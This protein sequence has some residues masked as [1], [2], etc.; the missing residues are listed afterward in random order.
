MTDRRA[1]TQPRT[2]GLLSRP[3][4]GRS[5]KGA[6]PRT[7][8]VRSVRPCTGRRPPVAPTL[9]FPGRAAGFDPAAAR[10][11]CNKLVF[12]AVTSI[13][14]STASP[15]AY[16]LLCVRFT[17]L[18]HTP[19]RLLTIRALRRRRNT[20]YGWVVSPYP[21]GTC[22]PH[23]TPSFTWHNNEPAHRRVAFWRVRWSALAHARSYSHVC[24]R[25]HCFLDMDGDDRENEIGLSGLEQLLCLNRYFRDQRVVFEEAEEQLW[26]R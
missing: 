20:R 24:I 10:A 12:G 1:G 19:H 16:R 3:R 5:G 6:L 23:D 17:C 13:S 26:I 15:M 11:D 9:H 14:G 25:E 7:P 22:T 21:A 4:P 8:G 2:D 18:V